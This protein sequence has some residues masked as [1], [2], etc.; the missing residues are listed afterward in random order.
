M[1]ELAKAPEKKISWGM[2]NP[3]NQKEWKKWGK[4]SI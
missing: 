1:F 4:V 2:Q 3:E